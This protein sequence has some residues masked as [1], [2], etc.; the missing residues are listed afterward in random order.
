MKN[1]LQPKLQAEQGELIKLREMVTSLNEENES[2]NS[3][4]DK[5]SKLKNEIESKDEQIDK[6]NREL[7]KLK[8]FVLESQEEQTQDSLNQENKINEYKLQIQQLESKLEEW[9]DITTNEREDNKRTLEKLNDLQ[10]EIETLREESENSKLEAQRQ[11]MSANNLQLVLE[12]FQASK[13]TDIQNALETMKTKLDSTMTELEE[14]RRKMKDVEGKVGN[15]DGVNVSQ[16]QKELQDK[17][18]LVGKLRRNVVQYQTH[19]AE[20]MR[21]IKSLSDKSEAN[22]DRRLITNLFVSYLNAPR[23]DRKRYEMLQLISNILH[24][25]DE[26]KYKAGLIKKPGKFLGIFGG[27]QQQEPENT[28][29]DMS[30]G[31]MWISFLMKEANEGDTNNS[32]TRRGSTTSNSAEI[33]SPL[34]PKLK[35]SKGSFSGLGGILNSPSSSTPPNTK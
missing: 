31:D 21:H 9:K 10:Q 34:T 7:T 30:F 20:A 25:T 11:A 4:V 3:Q 24:W 22:V 8:E 15:V 5:L 28:N 14:Y 23:G 16:L 27:G 13:E 32:F 33:S 2:L 26:E 17:N 29:S 19:L 6:L 1:A 35:N 12:Q 18:E